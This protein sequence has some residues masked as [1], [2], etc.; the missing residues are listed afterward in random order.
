MLTI[1][2]CDVEESLVLV[3]PVQQYCSCAIVCN[4]SAMN[5]GGV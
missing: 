5:G 2:L 4:A 1:F 3:R